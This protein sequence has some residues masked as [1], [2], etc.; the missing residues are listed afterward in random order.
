MISEEKKLFGQALLDATCRSYLTELASCEEDTCCSEAHTEKMTAILGLKPT[1]SQAIG[2]PRKRAVI[3]AILAA[4]LLLTGCAVYVYREK[5]A[6][7]IVTTFNDRVEIHHGN[8]DSPEY[9][10]EIEEKYTLGYVPEGYRLVNK[11]SSTSRNHSHTWKKDNGESILFDQSVI[12]VI[13]AK[14]H[15]AE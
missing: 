4:V 14:G 2:S 1:R 15:A 10:D 11:I 7:F 5:I 13:I 3:A 9:P 8:A 6:D 12:D